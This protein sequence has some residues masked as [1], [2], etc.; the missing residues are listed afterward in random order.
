MKGQAL[1]S[2]R[3][4]HPMIL[5]NRMLAIQML[6]EIG[7]EKINMLEDK[8]HKFIMEEIDENDEAKIVID[9]EFALFYAT[10][11]Q[12]EEL[13]ANFVKKVAEAEKASDT[14]NPSG[15]ILP[16]TDLDTGE[17]PGLIIT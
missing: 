7:A 3:N 4:K 6:R 1:I 9:W 8:H 2:Y 15:I 16:N 10:D 11:H 13:S 12:I 17:R 14:P 5:V